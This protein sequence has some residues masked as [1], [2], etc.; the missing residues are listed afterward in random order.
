[1]T[2]T[3]LSGRPTVCQVLPEATGEPGSL[4]ETMTSGGQCGRGH[5]LTEISADP[6]AVK[7]CLPVRAFGQRVDEGDDCI[8]TTLGQLGDEVDVDTS[9]PNVSPWRLGGVCR[10]GAVPP[11]PLTINPQD[12]LDEAPFARP[13]GVVGL[14]VAEIG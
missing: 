8:L 2:S 7:L 14:A 11:R 4:S 10:S 6:S 5:E 13:T 1:M 9:L 3:F 12:L